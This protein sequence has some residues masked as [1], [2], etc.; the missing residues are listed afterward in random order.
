[1]AV[2]GSGRD[3]AVLLRSSSLNFLTSLSILSRTSSI[4]ARVTPSQHPT[5][6]PVYAPATQGALDA[7]RCAGI[8]R[9]SGRRAPCP[10]SWSE[11][12]HG[13]RR[14]GA[15]GPPG[16]RER[17]GAGDDMKFNARN[18]NRKKRRVSGFLKRKS[19]R[20]GRKILKRRRQR[21]RSLTSI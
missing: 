20:A 5:Y 1:M 6:L 11:A 2:T 4:F 14:D 9:V 15:S 21:G 12:E 18:S 17:T 19:T 8:I 10:C 16:E 7:G 3:L 13:R